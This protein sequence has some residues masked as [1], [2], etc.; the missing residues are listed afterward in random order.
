MREWQ[1]LPVGCMEEILEARAYATAKAMTDAA[2]TTEAR[3]RL[4]QT[5]LFDL[6]KTI[7]FALAA[8]D[9]ERKTHG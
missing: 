3:Q 6:V 7:E 1:R 4:P 9:L 2:T 5:E 8:E